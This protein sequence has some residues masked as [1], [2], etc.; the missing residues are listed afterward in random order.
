MQ[1]VPKGQITTWHTCTVIK[2]SLL[3][4]S[5]SELSSDARVLKQIGEFVERYTVYTCGYGESPLGVQ[6]HYRLD[7][8]QKAWWFNPKLL[9]LHQYA[10]AYWTNPAVEQARSLLR[11]SQFDA[12]LANDFDTV[13][14]ALALQPRFGVH[15]DLHEYAPLQKENLLRWRLFVK[16]FRSWVCRKFLPQC[17]SVSVVGANI[18][19]K[20]FDMFKVSSEVVWNATPFANLQPS[21]VHDPIRLVHHGI[22]HPH[23]HLEVMLEAVKATSTP[24]SFDLYLTQPDSPYWQQLS[25]NYGS[26]PRINIRQP[27]PYS[28]LVSTLNN[29]DVGMFVLPP[30]TFNYRMALPNKF[31]DFIQA[32]LGLIVGPSP[33]MSK[34]VT[35]FQN[36]T[37]TEDF[38]VESLTR[39]LNDLTRARIEEWKTA[40]DRVAQRVAADGQVAKWAAA[41]ERILRQDD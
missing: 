5:F 29:Y 2:P 25:T 39:V 13:P 40:S 37:V 21:R 16:P 14:L 23:R 27:L 26:D 17:A 38:Q 34:L 10:R 19:Q 20:Y 1:Q 30:S 22:P 32:R 6:E 7:D 24:V 36:G 8:E 4:V 3:I 12:V 41:I 35:E 9:V 28:E 11:G 31:F 15:A 18:S 33:E